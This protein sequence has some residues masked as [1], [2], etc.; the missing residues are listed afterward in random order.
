MLAG[1][2]HIM[3]ARGQTAAA[4]ETLSA[5]HRL[6]G[7]EQ[8][9][10]FQ[11]FAATGMA[12]AGLALH[13]P[14]LALSFADDAVSLAERYGF[15]GFRIPALRVRGMV[16]AMTAGRAPEGHALLHTSIAAAQSLAMAGEVARG[17]AALAA[18]GAPDAAHHLDLA[19]TLHDAIG[20][21]AHFARVEH[22]IRLGHL[23]YI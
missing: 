5:A 21:T 7:A 2:G 4:S 20:L 8:R 14:D 13:E 17:H 16:L 19:R 9:W 3:L 11:I 12:L 1:L 6:A 23:P 10:M 15:H 18:V 22:E